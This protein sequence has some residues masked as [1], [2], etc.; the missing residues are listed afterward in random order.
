MCGEHSADAAVSDPVGGSSP[1]VRGAPNVIARVRGC[2][3]IIPACAGSTWFCGDR[4]RWRRDHPRM[5]GEHFNQLYMSAQR[6]GSSPHVRGAPWMFIFLLLYMGIIPA[7]AG[8]TT[9]ILPP[10]GLSRDHPRMCG[11]HD[12]DSDMVHSAAGS[13]PHVRGAHRTKVLFLSNAG[14]IPACAGST[15]FITQDIVSYRDHPRMCGEHC[16]PST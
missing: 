13:S 4:Q 12:Y 3:G 16:G 5:C 8:S 10:R 14:I 6:K 9:V 1:H 7:C 15:Y 11:E 2:S